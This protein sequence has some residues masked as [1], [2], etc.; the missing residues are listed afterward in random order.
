MKKNK[1]WIL[2]GV[3]AVLLICYAGIDKW[4]AAQEKKEAEKAKSETIQ[5]KTLDELAGIEYTYND[6]DFSFQKEEGSWKFKGD[7]E[8]PLEQSYVETMEDTFTNMT[9][10]RE[11][12]DG[13][14][15]S[16][17]GLEDPA[18]TISLTGTDG[19]KL[20]LYFGNTAEDNYYMTLGDKTKVYTVSS[21]MLSCIQYDLNSMMANDIFPVIG[22]E[23]VQSVSIETKQGSKQE[24][25]EYHAEKEEDK[26]KISVIAGGLGAVVLSDCADYYASGEE[27]TAFGLDKDTRTVVNVTYTK[28]DEE[29]NLIFYIGGEDGENRYVQMDGSRMVYRVSSET[30]KNVLGITE[31]E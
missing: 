13:D 15:L 25:E 14:E 7:P 20:D 6:A 9:A 11:L 5:I 8:F 31:T 23:S 18:Y 30:I 2:L 21:S 24:T 10:L 3:L 1:L 4:N 22:N 16:A 29:E 27:E 17:Y 28:G 19:T 12:K 26:D